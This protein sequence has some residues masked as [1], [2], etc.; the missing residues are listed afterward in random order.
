MN[1][2]CSNSLNFICQFPQRPLLRLRGLCAASDL[3]VL[4]YPTFISATG[5][6]AGEDS[7]E[8]IWAGA[9]GTYIRYNQT[10]LLWTAREHRL[11]IEFRTQDKC[12]RRYIGCFS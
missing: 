10:A 7:G 1:D 4:Y 2:F 3:D 8:F 6:A 9:G 12:R 11:T 5:S